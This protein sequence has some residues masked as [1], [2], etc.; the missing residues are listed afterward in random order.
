MPISELAFAVLLFCRHVWRQPIITMW[1]G[2]V[3]TMK[4]ESLKACGTNC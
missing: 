1:S 2:T 3:L 4:G